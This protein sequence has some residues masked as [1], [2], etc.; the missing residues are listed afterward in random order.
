MDEWPWRKNRMSW[1]NKTDGVKQFSEDLRKLFRKKPKYGK[2]YIIEFWNHI[3]IW[4][5]K[6]PEKRLS[7]QTNTLDFKTQ[8]FAWASCEGWFDR[9]KIYRK[10]DKKSTSKYQF[11][12][13]TSQLSGNFEAPNVWL[14]LQWISVSQKKNGNLLKPEKSRT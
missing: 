1:P 11:K 2:F 3:F 14:E 4:D 8:V 5:K 10:Q 9:D 12:E 13:P 7:I 6:V